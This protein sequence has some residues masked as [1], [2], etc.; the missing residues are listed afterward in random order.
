MTVTATGPWR[1][2]AKATGI[3]AARG[4]A[5]CHTAQSIRGKAGT[6]LPSTAV[7][8]A[9]AA[10]A[11]PAKWGRSW[12]LRVMSTWGN[13]AASTTEAAALR[14]PSEVRRIPTWVCTCAQVVVCCRPRKRVTVG[15]KKST[16]SQVAYGS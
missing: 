11:T 6:R 8:A 4:W 9:N 13:N 7:S 5:S 3:F 1:N 15:L 16:R 10:W 14:A 12:R 2:T